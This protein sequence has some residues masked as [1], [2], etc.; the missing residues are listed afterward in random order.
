MN[1]GLPIYPYKYDILDMIE[2]NDVTIITSE[3]GSG[4]STQVCQYLHEIGYRVYITEPR[5]IATVSLADIVSRESSANIAYHTGFESTETGDSDIIFCTD[6]LQLVRELFRIRIQD[7]DDTKRILIIDEIHEWNLNQETLLAWIMSQY[8]IGNKFTKVVLMSATIEATS[9]LQYCKKFSENSAVISIPGKMYPV[10]ET[11]LSVNKKIDIIYNKILEGRNILV[12]EPGVREIEEVINAIK[13]KCATASTKVECLPLYGDLDLK[14]Q[15][16]AFEKYSVPKVVVATN[17]AQ[18]SITIPDIDCVCDSGLEKKKFYEMGVEGLHLIDISKADIIQR[19]GRAGRVKPGEYFLFEDPFRD[20]FREDYPVEEINRAP[21]DQVVLRLL[22]IGLDA[23]NLEFYHSPESGRIKDAKTVLETLGAMENGNI[24][25]MGRRMSKLPVSTRSARLLIEADK[26]GCISDAII[27]VAIIECGSIMA[28]KSSGYPSFYFSQYPE[29]TDP[30]AEVMLY[31][32]ALTFDKKDLKDNGINAKAFF[33]V[34]D[35]VKKLKT[36]LR[37]FYTIDNMTYDF[38]V[39]NDAYIAANIDRIFEMSYRGEFTDA[40]RWTAY[41]QDRKSISHYESKYIIAIPTVITFTNRYGEE[42]EMN[43]LKMCVPADIKKLMEKYPQFVTTELSESK[44]DF[45]YNPETDSIDGLQYTRFMGYKVKEEMVDVPNYEFRNELKEKYE[46]AH[47]PAIKYFAEPEFVPRKLDDDIIIAGKRFHSSGWIDRY[48][49]VWIDEEELKFLLNSGVTTARNSY[50][51][52]IIFK[53]RSYAYEYLTISKENI[54]ELANAY[55][56]REKYGFTMHILDKYKEFGKNGKVKKIADF[57]KLLEE[58]RKPQVY[59]ST[60]V[61]Y[62]W[63]CHSHAS[64]EGYYLKLSEGEDKIAD[65]NEMVKRFLL[66]YLEDEYGAKRFRVKISG[67]MSYTNK[68]QKI[69][70]EF[71]QFAESIINDATVDNFEDIVAMIDE[72]YQEYTIPIR[73]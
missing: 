66:G 33:R 21:L 35:L 56:E 43:L 23:E 8:K 10:T 64:P 28:Y 72:A 29:L 42:C 18:T 31:K 25:E 55:A 39:L 46:Q 15:Q 26:L 20:N 52:P 36:S 68:C 27:L 41:R 4:K 9:L 24:T 7:K 40:G 37:D 62:P 70:V 50:G 12:F 17:I 69:Y 61:F 59:L 22:A 1:Y 2:G 19:K 63:I 44:W 60:L 54:K 71:K 58:I 16:K 53:I 11:I 13:L 30:M 5:R 6:G 57:R 47:R 14:E 49:T 38:Y 48:D 45:T 3:P 67:K 65:N 32:E 51:A 34:L 73:T